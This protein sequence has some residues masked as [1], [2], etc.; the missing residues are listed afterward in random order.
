M[1]TYTIFVKSNKHPRTINTPM[2]ARTNYDTV[3]VDSKEKVAHAVATLRARGE[4]VLCVKTN[5]G[6][7]V[8][9]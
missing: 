7:D 5:L 6:T 3:E 1:T 4:V 8:A 2:M 9:F